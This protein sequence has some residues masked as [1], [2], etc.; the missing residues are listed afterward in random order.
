MD[1]IFE[2]CFSKYGFLYACGFAIPD[3]GM[4]VVEMMIERMADSI[5]FLI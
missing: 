4:K 5:S 3:I 1:G 2:L